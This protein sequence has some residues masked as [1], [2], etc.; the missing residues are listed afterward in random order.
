[1][2]ADAPRFV[3]EESGTASLDIGILAEEEA[4]TVPSLP[5]VKAEAIY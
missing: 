4:Y 5:P 3:F 1:M 2:G